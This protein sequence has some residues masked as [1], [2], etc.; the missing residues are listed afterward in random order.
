V[1]ARRPLLLYEPRGP[2]RRLPIELLLAAARVDDRA[3]ELVDGRLEV[4]PERRVV[5]LCREAALLAV[6]APSGPALLDAQRISRAA[7]AAR[8]D[9][10][11]L[12]LGEHAT[13]RPRECLEAGAAACAVGSVENTLPE[14]LGV[15]DAGIAA[16]RVPGLVRVDGGREH[17][18][19]VRADFGPPPTPVRFDRLDLERHFRWRGE[20]RLPYRSSRVAAA[21]PLSPAERRWAGVPAEV[22]VAELAE[23]VPRARATGV[24][25]VDEEFFADLRRAESIARG[26][27]ATGVRAGWTARGRVETLRLLT[28]DAV[29]ALRQSGCERVRVEVASGSAGARALW[30]GAPDEAA[31]LEL[32]HKLARGGLPARWEFVVGRPGEPRD[33]LFETYRFARRLHRVTPGS[34]TP[35]DLWR[36][37]AVG[38]GSQQGPGV[39]EPADVAGW[40]A[41]ATREPD[42]IAAPVRRWARRFDFY[43]RWAHRRPERGLGRW[44]IHFLARV[45]V[46]T[47]VYGLDVERGLVELSRRLRT[48]N[49]A[50]RP[51]SSGWEP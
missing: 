26:L 42:W 25:F 20:R 41:A 28:E 35:I 13:A 51:G 11:V 21:P 49:K 36:P 23:W 24:D 10:F 39:P 5:E 17:D 46:A 19:G 15:L 4:A 45:R 33:A 34:E 1:S 40:A 37:R 31:V 27:V 18:T 16:D 8:A 2:G 3:V 29:L 22:V 47:G 7:R 38:L 9:L 32:A 48:A 14:L 50:A 12:W 6:A 43:L 30:A 44:L